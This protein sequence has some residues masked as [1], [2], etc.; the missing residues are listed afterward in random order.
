M[1]AA[2]GAAAAPHDAADAP[3]DA[4]G[5][6]HEDHAYN[7]LYFLFLAL[8]LGALA[9]GAVRGSRLPYTVA[10]LFVGLALGFLHAY[11][12][13]GSLGK[14]L[15]IWV[16]IGPH[17]M[18]SCFLPALVFESAFSLEWH[19]FRRCASQVIWLAGPGVLMGTGLMGALLKA[20]IPYDWGWGSSLMLGSILS[21]TDPVAVV[22]LLKEVGASK[23]L[24]HII[25]GESLVN[26]GTAIVVFSLLNEIAKGVDKT[27]LEIFTFFLWVP[28][29][30]VAVGVACAAGC[31][32]WLGLGAVA[33]DHVVQISV[34]LFACYLCFLVAEFEAEASGVLAV[35]ILGVSVGAFG[36]GFFTGETENAT[37]VFW[38]ML[39]FVANTVLFILTGV[40]IAEKTSEST[41]LGK[42]GAA[43]LGWGLLVY[44]E[45]LAARAFVVACLFP[46]LR[47]RGY[48]LTPADAAVCVWGGLRG[49]VGLALALAVSEGEREYVDEN[50][51]PVTLLCT[52][53]V[54]VLTLA[55]NGTTTGWLLQRLGLTRPE[56]DVQV[57]VSKA[58]RHIRE[59]C[60]AT[61]HEHLTTSDDV[62]G[63]ADFRA[64]AELVPFL[65][66]EDETATRGNGKDDGAREK[67]ADRARDEG[68]AERSRRGGVGEASVSRTLEAASTRAG[69]VGDD[70][71]SRGGSSAAETVVDVRDVAP[72]LGMRR[73][74]PGLVTPASSI[75]NL[76]AFAEAAEKAE[77]ETASSE[78]KPLSVVA[79]ESSSAEKEIESA[80]NRN[81]LGVFGGEQ[82]DLAAAVERAVRRD[83]DAAVAVWARD[84][85]GRFLA[86]LK[87]LYWESLEEGRATKEVVETLV[88]CADVA[89]DEL[90]SPMSDWKALR[91]L[92][93][94][95]ASRASRPWKRAY[96]ALPARL[97]TAVRWVRRWVLHTGAVGAGGGRRRA[98]VAAALF[99]DAHREASH[100][101]FGD[102]E[103][104]ANHNHPR[105]GGGAGGGGFD[106]GGI[107]GAE[108]GSG[109]FL[110]HSDGGSG[111]GSGSLADR[112]AHMEDP[113]E[114]AIRLVRGECE[115]TTRLA[116]SY[117]RAARTNEP[118]L[119]AAVKSEETARRLLAVAERSAR[120][121]VQSGLLTELEADELLSRIAVA[122]RRL[123]LDPPEPVNRDPTELMRMSP[124]M[125]P[126]R[127][128]RV[129]DASLAKR[130]VDEA[131]TLLTRRF[132]GDS[133]RPRDLCPP[134]GLALLARGVVDVT[135]SRPIGDGGGGSDAPLRVGASST[136]YGWALGAAD[137]LLPDAARFD[138]KA[139]SAVAAF[140]F[141]PELAVAACRCENTRKA[142]WRAAFGLLAATLMKDELASLGVP[143]R[144][145]RAAVARA[146]IAER[147][148]GEDLGAE[149][150]VEEAPPRGGGLLRRDGAEAA[151]TTVTTITPPDC[152][153]V[154]LKGEVEDPEQGTLRGPCVVYP[155]VA[156][157][158]TDARA[159]LFG[160][161]AK[162]VGMA[163][164]GAAA[165]TPEKKP[166]GAYHPG[167]T[168]SSFKPARR[169]LIVQERAT[170]LRVSVDAHANRL[171]GGAGGA[172][173]TGDASIAKGG[174]SA[175]DAK[176]GGAKKGPSPRH[177]SSAAAP[178]KE[179]PSYAS[180]LPGL[181]GSGWGK[182]G[183]NPLLLSRGAGVPGP[184]DG[185]ASN[186][187]RRLSV[188]IGALGRA[189]ELA[190]ERSG[191][192]GSNATSLGARGSPRKKAVR[193]GA[194]PATREEEEGDGPDGGRPLAASDEDEGFDGFEPSKGSWEDLRAAEAREMQREARLAAVGASFPPKTTSEGSDVWSSSL[195]RTAARLLSRDVRR[196]VFAPRRSV[197][198]ALTKAVAA[199]AAAMAGSVMASQKGESPTSS[200]RSR[201]LSA[202]APPALGPETFR[203]DNNSNPVLG[204]GASSPSSSGGGGGG[205]GGGGSSSSSFW[206]SRRVRRVSG[207][208]APTRVPSDRL[209]AW[210][211]GEAGAGEFDV[212]AGRE[213]FPPRGQQQGGRGAA[214][215][216][217]GS[218]PPGSDGAGDATAGGSPFDTVGTDD[219]SEEA[220]IRF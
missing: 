98:L 73:T 124:L 164:D 132:P 72:T 26:D 90:D 125:D 2:E 158:M 181:E 41:S 113:S 3:H 4:G 185:G 60:M 190:A 116:K 27:P 148:P 154:L 173:Q 167:R 209:A 75:A 193:F 20:T 43:D 162:R 86:H 189:A 150:P 115:E 89:L 117:L 80:P 127:D 201:R 93:L 62:M 88:E 1:A 200:L 146:E 59:Q 107:G 122:Q 83:F 140:A 67:A 114:A 160:K 178:P 182:F 109:A 70:A 33:G 84:V 47:R 23:R 192:G 87:V 65:K 49:A 42:I 17:T 119:A 34:T 96:R 101:I 183:K 176:N 198:D 40:I 56:V 37:H 68:S 179:A 130:L 91:Q 82:P 99:H 165:Q 188:N 186:L 38:E 110:S 103:S 25:E 166:G 219:G 217:S 71:S 106:G 100:A 102:E 168:G 112:H 29:G 141:P 155:S 9:R 121:Y 44:A 69:D 30:A 92:L 203:R 10:L 214:A 159:E 57:A 194:L 32:A 153:V 171:G 15:D 220:S 46:I 210:R 77:G 118:E 79:E 6:G 187:A 58:T 191:E 14:S 138:V 133:A 21:A 120:G 175:L 211:R 8:V 218:S 142:L 108:S 161:L 152:L 48:G 174:S 149:L 36:R 134:G 28:F 19:T 202:R 7:A 205:G 136:S 78:T 63:T 157:G 55:V 137:L 206:G 213:T 123:R 129:T 128:A 144:L 195:D 135:W 5:A 16:S 156:R 95:K 139:V 76:A 94:G 204:R 35:V 216:M 208:S 143:A 111:G 52:G 163:A 184:D 180:Y 18:L 39:T 64:V 170:V 66:D 172:R 61:Y 81:A 126:T 145:T 151:E 13:L 169:E 54:V 196:D 147:E 207:S 131:P 12:D 105:D 24:G 50:V 22:A 11:V 31:H 212:E 199:E 177:S 85:R 45:V 74:K 53:V 104:S 97:R 215:V 197:G 51:G